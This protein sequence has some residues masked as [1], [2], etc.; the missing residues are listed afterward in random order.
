MSDQFHL[1][2]YSLQW[3]RKQLLEEAE[4]QRL[5]RLLPRRPVTLRL[6]LAH[7]LFALASWLSP[8]VVQQPAV[9][10]LARATR[11]NGIL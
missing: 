3:R 5:A 2:D 11:R 9:F 1:L 7:A 10:E 4:A 8:D 6:R